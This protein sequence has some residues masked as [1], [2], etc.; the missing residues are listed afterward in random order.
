MENS[1]LPKMA[2]SRCGDEKEEAARDVTG[3]RN[4]AGPEEEGARR[5]G[6]RT[7][8]G[9]YLIQQAPTSHLHPG[10]DS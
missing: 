6:T 2:L 4:Q 7:E 1:P 9:G 3:K 10:P 8:K 5:G